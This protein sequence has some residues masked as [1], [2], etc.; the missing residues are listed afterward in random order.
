[1]LDAIK[2]TTTTT[3][4]D[5]LFDPENRSVWGEFDAR[6]R[7]IIIGC[8]RRLGVSDDD[9]ADLAQETLA[10]FIQEYRLGKYDRQRGRLRSWIIAMLKY[11]VADLQRARAK[12]REQ[13]G[14]SAMVD[15]SARDDFDA[16]WEAER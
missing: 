8:A 1:M 11:R 6:Y 15:L 10:R 13:R 5:G 9:A 16:V 4:L 3:L 14:D 7:P 2:T 12:R